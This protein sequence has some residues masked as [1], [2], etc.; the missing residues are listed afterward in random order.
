MSDALEQRVFVLEQQMAAI[1]CGRK[2]EFNRVPAVGMKCTACE[3][4]IPGYTGGPPLCVD[5]IAAPATT[6]DKE[7]PAGS[8]PPPPVEGVDYPAQTPAAEDGA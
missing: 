1:V 4:E 8:E 2:V 7:T 5:C 6:T 3:A